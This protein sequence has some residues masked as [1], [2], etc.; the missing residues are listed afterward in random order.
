MWV[1]HL[2]QNGFDVK[3]TDVPD[4]TAVKRRVGV[5]RPLTSCHTALIDGYIVEG[6]VPADD[7]KRLLAERPGCCRCLCAW[8]AGWIAWDGRSKPATLRRAGVRRR[9][10]L[11]AL[12]VALAITSVGSAQR[13]PAAAEIGQE[14][15]TDRR[16]LRGPFPPAERVFRAHCIDASGDNDTVSTHVHAINQQPHQV[17]RVERR[18]PPRIQLRLSLRDNASTDRTRARAPRGGRRRRAVPDSAHTGGSPHRSASGRPRA[19]SA[20]PHSRMPGPL[21]TEPPRR[22]GA[23]GAD[24][25]PPS[26][27]PAQP[28]SAY[29]PFDTPGAQVAA[30]TVA[31]R[32]RP[33][34][35]GLEFRIRS[36]NRGLDT[37][38]WRLSSDLRCLAHGRISCSPCFTWPSQPRSSADPA[39]C[40]PS[41]L[42]I[43]CSSSS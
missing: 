17:Q 41:S 16:V 35:V 14:P 13:W 26:A 18:R 11:H 38:A 39:A 15:L 20:G 8:H 24:E 12:R 4:M 28:D 40:E 27:R 6:H 37:I 10:I 23:H 36:L 5:P 31:H 33:D 19:G 7:I 43:S 9:R 1:A 30:H 42:R 29:A 32:R 25:S 3:S 2:E 22:R 34:P 21:A